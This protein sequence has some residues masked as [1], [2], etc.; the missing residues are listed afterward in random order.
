MNSGQFGQGQTYIMPSHLFPHL[1]DYKGWASQA[2]TSVVAFLHTW[3]NTAAIFFSLYI[4]WQ[5][6]RSIV[7]WISSFLALRRLHGGIHRQM[8]YIPCPEVFRLRKYSKANRKRS[9][10]SHSRRPPTTEG[11]ESEREQWVQMK[12]AERQAKVDSASGPTTSAGGSASQ[13]IPPIRPTAPSA[14]NIPITTDVPGANPHGR[15]SLS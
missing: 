4:F 15:K 2:Y 12:E 1:P 13:P 14:S 5:L 8:W 6:A 7:N 9:H 3:G 11:M 10:R